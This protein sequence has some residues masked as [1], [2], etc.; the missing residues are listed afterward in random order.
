MTYSEILNIANRVKDELAPHCHRIEIAGSIR[1]K[2]PE[3]RDI[4]IV[5]I[6]KP[7]QVG[8]FESGFATVVNQWPK[9][10]GVLPSRYT[11]RL[12]P[13]GVKLDLFIANRHNWGMILAIRTGSAQFS[14]KALASKWSAMGYRSEAGVLYD[15]KG[16]TCEIHEEEDLFKL[17]G[18]PYIKPEEREL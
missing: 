18:L 13:E 5:C 8:L 9:V 16:N 1:R 2:H 6:P 7:Y 17:L 3:C 15:R 14:H 10:K 11:Q 12:L 4:E